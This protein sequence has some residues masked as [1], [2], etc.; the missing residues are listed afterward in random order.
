MHPA[1]TS[2]MFTLAALYVRDGQLEKSKQ[3][4]LNTLALESAN[5][6]A[7]NLLEEVEHNLTGAIAE[8][9]GAV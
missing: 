8:G 5:K 4:L 7:A 2:V 1:D 3:V 6:D 9:I